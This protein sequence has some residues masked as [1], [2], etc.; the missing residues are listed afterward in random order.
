MQLDG[1]IKKAG[2][3]CNRDRDVSNDTKLFDLENC[4]I[5]LESW[6]KI[7]TQQDL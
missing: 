6:K 7:K 1:R 3:S 5:R 4:H 2:Q